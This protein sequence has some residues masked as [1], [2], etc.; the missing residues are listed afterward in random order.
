MLFI[1]GLS[2]PLHGCV[3]DFKPETIQDVIVGTRDMEGEVPKTNTFSKEFIPHKGKYKKP[4][5]K[6]GTSKERLD[7]ATHNDLRK[8]N[9]FFSYKESWALGH[10]CMGK[11][12][13]RYIEVHSDSDEE[14]EVASR[15]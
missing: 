11:G 5:V 14:E 9:I 3:K 6:E 13:V 2:E 7:E 10:R 1:E 15:A 12:K 4:P 8:K